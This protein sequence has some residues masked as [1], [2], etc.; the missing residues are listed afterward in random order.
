MGGADDARFRIGQQ[1]FI[2]RTMYSEQAK[3]NRAAQLKAKGIDT[4]ISRS[5]TV[6]EGKR[7][8]FPLGGSTV[9]LRR[10]RSGVCPVMR[11]KE[12]QK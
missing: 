7:G 11:R 9:R 4:K 5:E 1:M 8:L 2:T 10:Q 12:R 6:P 3:E